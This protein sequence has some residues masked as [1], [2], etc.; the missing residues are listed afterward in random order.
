MITTYLL[1]VWCTTKNGMSGW[2][3]A[4]ESKSMEEIDAFIERFVHD[5]KSFKIIQRIETVIAESYRKDVIKCKE[6][7][8][9]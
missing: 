2:R 8:E 5:D 4:Q 3:I 7:N 6:R 1:M 9:A